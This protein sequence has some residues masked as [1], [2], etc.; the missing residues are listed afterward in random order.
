MA[1]R[2]QAR[3]QAERKNWRKDHPEHF[4]AKPG[5]K[6]D[7]TNDLLLWTIKIPAKP[8]SIW[9][10]GLFSGTMRFTEDFPE[11][12]PEVKFDRI[13]GKVLFHPNVYDNGG[14]CLNIINPPESS[15]G[16]GMGG[17]WNISITIPQVMLAL[18]TFLDEPNEKSPAQQE[19][20]MIYKKDRAEYERRVK[21]QVARVD[22][23][24]AT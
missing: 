5:T 23:L 1:S 21:L 17:D 22:Q 14:V 20:F 13:D 7:G 24:N 8:S 2:A 19:A 15:H 12:P 16:Y 10:P 9:Y 4:V 6:A 11:R 18:Q 3:L